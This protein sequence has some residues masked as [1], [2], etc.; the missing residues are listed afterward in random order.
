ME[1]H[2]NFSVAVTVSVLPV[3]YEVMIEGPVSDSVSLRSLRL[4]HEEV[5]IQSAKQL[6]VIVPDTRNIC[7][8]KLAGSEALCHQAAA[9][10]FSTTGAI[11]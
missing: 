5:N 11:T 8:P 3:T 1:S 4:C 10:E 9:V 7:N 6:S 2:F